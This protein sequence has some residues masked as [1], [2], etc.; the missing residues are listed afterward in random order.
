MTNTVLFLLSAL[1]AG[2]PT[3]AETQPNAKPLRYTTSWVGNTFGGGPKWVQNA[4]ESMQILPD[5]T[6]VVGSF[7]DEGSREVGLYKDGDVVGQLPDTHMRAGFAVAAN[8]HYFFY[9]HTCGL[10]NQ[11]HAKSGEA[12]REKP[13]CYFGVSRYTRDGKHAPFPG[14]KTRFKNMLTFHEAQDNHTLIP[15]GVAASD[16]TLFVAD[17]AFDSIKVIDLENDGDHP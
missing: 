11:P 14:G 16:R 2:E 6:L 15:R 5:G 9:A 1:A 12:I 3:H 17:T 10:E 13:I 4:A 7:W 8:E